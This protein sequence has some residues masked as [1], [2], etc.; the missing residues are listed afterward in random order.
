MGV[1]VS[2]SLFLFAISPVLVGKQSTSNLLLVI[3]RCVSRK[4]ETF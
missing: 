2:P 4:M 1:G 3:W